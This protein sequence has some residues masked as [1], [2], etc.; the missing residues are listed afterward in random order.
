MGDR[1]I[2]TETYARR[3]E[4][5]RFGASLEERDVPW[6]SFVSLAIVLISWTANIR[7]PGGVPGELAAIVLGTAIGWIAHLFGWSGV[8]GTEGADAWEIRAASA[9]SR[10]RGV[11][12]TC[13]YRSAVRHGH[14]VRRLYFQRGHNARALLIRRSRK[15]SGSRPRL[16]K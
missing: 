9:R 6:I 13:E 14:P 3:R 8:Q 2:R 16:T 5:G 15:K 10:R 1:R 4:G 12:G 7:L 11:S